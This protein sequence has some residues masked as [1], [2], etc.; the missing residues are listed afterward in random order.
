MFTLSRRIFRFVIASVLL[1]VGIPAFSVPAQAATPAAKIPTSIVWRLGPNGCGVKPLCSTF[2]GLVADASGRVIDSSLT[3]PPYPESVTTVIKPGFSKVSASYAGNATYAPSSATREVRI[4]QPSGQIVGGTTES[5]GPLQVRVSLSDPETGAPSGGYVTLSSAIGQPETKLVAGSTVFLVSGLKA[6][7]QSVSLRAA[8]PEYSQMYAFGGLNFEILPGSVTTTSAPTTTQPSTTTTLPSRALV[9]TLLATAPLI[10]TPSGPYEGPWGKYLSVRPSGEVGGGSSGSEG[11]F[12]VLCGGTTAPVVIDNGAVDPLDRPV[13]VARGFGVQTVVVR[14]K[15]GRFATRNVRWIASKPVTVRAVAG[16]PVTFTLKG[17]PADL[18]P[19]FD[20]PRGTEC[21]GATCTIP[22]NLV[23]VPPAGQ[24]ALFNWTD[25][26]QNPFRFGTVILDVV[27]PTTTPPTS[28]STTV[29]PST[30]IPTSIGWRLTPLGCGAKLPCDGYTGWVADAE[31]KLLSP[32][33][34]FPPAVQT[35]I[36]FVKPGLTRISASYAG[37][38]TYSPSSGTREIRFPRVAIQIEGGTV[39]GS[40]PLQVRV[41]LTDP[42]TGVSTG[43]LASVV[44]TPGRFPPLL[45][46]NNASFLGGSYVFPYGGLVAGD[47]L[48]TVQV[49]DTVTGVLF[50]TSRL[51][52]RITPADMTTTTTSVPTTTAPITT[53]PGNS[54]KWIASPIHN[55]VVGP[56]VKMQINDASNVARVD[57]Y[58]NGII[59]GSDITPA[60]PLTFNA[61]GWGAGP[62]AL[63]AVIVDRA[64]KET[65]TQ[66]VNFSVR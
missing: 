24:R 32:D 31:G 57:W 35:A 66:T 39:E 21:V 43:A 52:V 60:D 58:V 42:Q 13:C 40:G 45:V 19:A 10:A 41:S 1:A 38:T 63:K 34:T 49:P 12:D 3:S 37:N 22:G 8:N 25:I 48:V 17:Q 9:L 47:Y 20:F 11:D 29:P 14:D 53:T 30:K 28:T 50:E 4:P 23:V 33:E 18:R 59:I 7:P 16:Q 64:Y 5:D 54:T 62:F 61:Q 56:A 15:L 46:P 2:V 55:S 51:S 26:G 27:P 44:V 6:G 65:T 36:S